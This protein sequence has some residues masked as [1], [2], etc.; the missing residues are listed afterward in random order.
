MPQQRE[1]REVQN[2]AFLA[3]GTRND[4]MIW[5]QQVGL[6]RLY[7][8]PEIAVEIG[9]AGMA[10]SCMG[11]AVTITPDMVGKRV[12]VLCQPEFKTAKGKQ[13]EAQHRWQ[14][15]VTAIG[16]IYRLIRSPEE[17]LKMVEDVQRGRW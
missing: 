9:R 5:R 1:T 17:L 4:V 13:A 11:V 2:P 16:G 6:Y 14:R 8:N 10:D 7:H 12:A 3:V 15:A